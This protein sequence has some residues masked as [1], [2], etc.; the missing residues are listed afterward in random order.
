MTT[1][2][3]TSRIWPWHDVPDCRNP[4]CTLPTVTVPSRADRAAEGWDICPRTLFCPACGHIWDEADPAIVD[5]AR[6]AWK[7]WERINSG[8]VSEAWAKQM[9]LDEERRVRLAAEAKA[10]QITLPWAETTD[11]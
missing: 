3:T 2:E 5:R 10:A 6:R 1:A 9:V 8:E 11:G 4:K 7:W